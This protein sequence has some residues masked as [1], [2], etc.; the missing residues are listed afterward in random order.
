MATPLIFRWQTARIALIAALL[1]GTLGAI[2]RVIAVN[3]WEK[4]K[5]SAY[6]YDFP[7][8]VPL[9]SWQLANSQS[10]AA[11]GK[12]KNVGQRYQYRQNGQELEVQVRYERYTDSNIS[13][14]LNIYT[15][16]KGATLTLNAKRQAGIGYY[17]LLQYEERAYLSACLN[18]IG[19]STIT[20]QQFTQ[21]RYEHGWS[22]QRVFLWGIGQDD[23]IESRCFWTLLSTPVPAA[24]DGTTLAAAYQT[25]E[26]AWFDWYRWWQSRL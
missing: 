15:P 9:A 2:A 3:L 24:A 4:D 25:L 20:Q 12:A 23:L 22:I 26:S 19:E 13:R 1:A 18:P 14:L 17:A 8:T 6:T 10:L 16:I 11:D 21:N 5:P 7:K